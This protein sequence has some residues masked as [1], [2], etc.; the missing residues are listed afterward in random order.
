MTDAP[1]GAVGKH[2]LGGSVDH[3]SQLLT[4]EVSRNRLLEN[5]NE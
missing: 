2:G 4:R 1:D 3:M 5:S